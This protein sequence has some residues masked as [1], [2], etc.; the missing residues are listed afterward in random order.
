MDLPDSVES[1]VVEAS[2][3][4]GLKKI[5]SNA[6][7]VVSTVGPFFLHGT[8]LVE[9]CVETG[10][11]YCD[12][13]GETPWIKQII[14]RYHDKAIRNRSRIVPCCSF[15]SLPFDL[16]TY[17]LVDHMK[18]TMDRKCRSVLAVI[19]DCKAGISGGTIDSLFNLM[20]QD[21]ETMRSLQDPY[22]LHPK[23]GP[24]KGPDRSTLDTVF[25]ARELQC[26]VGPSLSALVNAKVVRRTNALLMNR[27]G[28][29]FSYD[30]GE[31]RKNLVSG[32]LGWMAGKV[33]MTFLRFGW[34]RKTLRKALPAPGSA[35]GT[36]GEEGYCNLHFVGKTEPIG[37]ETSKTLI[38]DMKGT[39]DPHYSGTARMVVEAAL[40]L[41]FQKEQ[42]QNEGYPMGGCLTPAAAM[43]H[44]LIDRLQRDGFIRYHVR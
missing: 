12:T 17:Y 9:A 2:D 20:N 25:Y 22:E 35:I 39:M 23:D 16:G 34:I 21:A 29:H 15:C 3:L 30:E 24:P 11:D 6:K 10:T 43:G 5:T 4:E 19:G 36:I 1:L 7:A 40:C 28:D 27:Y 31:I 42:L 38:V 41:V 32:W 13:T 33:F 18:R 37:N 26:T 14:E 8:P 44:V